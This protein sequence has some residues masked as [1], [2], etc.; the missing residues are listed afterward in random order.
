MTW[1][2]R[3]T[4]GTNYFIKVR[5]QIEFFPFFLV[6]SA[7]CHQVFYSEGNST[8][9]AFCR[10]LVLHEMS[11]CEVGVVDSQSVHYYFCFS[12]NLVP[13]VAR[14]SCF[15]LF[16]VVW[17]FGSTSDKPCILC[18]YFYVFL[19]VLY[20]AI[21]LFSFGYT[22]KVFACWSVRSFPWILQCPGVQINRTF[23]FWFFGFSTWFMMLVA[24]SLV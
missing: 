5:W 9:G 19:C 16:R 23:L 12:C 2:F 14:G 24:I 1:L 7:F 4:V 11:E 3:L 17:F 22:I 18:D 21:F 8:W 10:W 13:I 15:V 20:C 6:W